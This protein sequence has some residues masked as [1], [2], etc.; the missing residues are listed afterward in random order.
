MKIRALILSIILAQMAGAIGSFFT[1]SSVRDWYNL[2][3]MPSFSPPSWVFGPV[4]LMLYTLMG[5]AAYLVWL[6]KKKK[7]SRRALIVYGIH[8]GLNTLWS[9]LFFGLH[10]PGAAFVEI[11]ILLGFIVYTC[12]LFWKIDSRAG[13]LMV[14]YILWVSFASVLNGAI[15]FLNI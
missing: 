10:N 12:V 1:A 15:Y 8:L 3:T 14:P 11:L 7:G 6:Q 2:L 5:I 4:W 9:I 13:W